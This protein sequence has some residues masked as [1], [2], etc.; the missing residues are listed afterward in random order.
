MKI[1]F[2]VRTLLV[3]TA[4]FAVFFALQVHVH[5]KANRFVEKV[6]K[7]SV[8]DKRIES[9]S[10][11]PLSITDVVCFQRRCEFQVEV[12]DRMPTGGKIVIQQTIN[13]RIQCFD[14]IYVQ[15]DGSITAVQ[16]K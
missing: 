4:I 3:V 5:N 2:K 1:R 16:R 13:Y 14:E 9:A 8:P 12:T 7:S 15:E 11:M 10:L 6:R